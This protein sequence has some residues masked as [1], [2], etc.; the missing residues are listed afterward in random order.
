VA[1]ENSITLRNDNDND[2]STDR[3][4]DRSHVNYRSI[5]APLDGSVLAERALPIAAPLARALGSMLVLMQSV[6][7]ENALT[8]QSAAL[9]RSRGE[10]LDYLR[11]TAG[12][13]A[14]IT[15][16]PISPWWS[17]TPAT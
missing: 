12:R 6:L 8:G 15:L 1:L 10:A 17:V 13:L 9:L 3:S 14:G 2:L 16:L 7:P 4:I 11:G 5:L